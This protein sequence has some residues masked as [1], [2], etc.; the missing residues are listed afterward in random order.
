MTLLQV[1]ERYRIATG[2]EKQRLRELAR[3]IMRWH[4]STGNTGKG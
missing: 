1:I 3:A 2:E 4:L